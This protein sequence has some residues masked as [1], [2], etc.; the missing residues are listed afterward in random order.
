[1]NGFEAVR[2]LRGSRHFLLA[3]QCVALR[4]PWM[5]ALLVPVVRVPS[6][7]RGPPGV[8]FTARVQKNC[9]AL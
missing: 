2:L 7:A 4:C 6:Y 9:T 3:P 1:M 5:S 8:L